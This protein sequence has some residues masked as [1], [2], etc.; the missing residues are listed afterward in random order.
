MHM[1]NQ[2]S[3]DGTLRTWRWPSR[4]GESY[5]GDQVHMTL[6]HV[7]LSVEKIVELQRLEER[8]KVADRKI[9]QG[10]HG[11]NKHRGSLKNNFGE[12][13]KGSMMQSYKNAQAVASKKNQ[14]SK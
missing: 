11:D 10:I 4:L 12:D 5:I 1:R 13:P 7:D 9:V 14:R 6:E 2:L 8:V 3:S